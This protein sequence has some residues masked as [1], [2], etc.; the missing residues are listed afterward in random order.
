V[1]HSFYW[2]STLLLAERTGLEPATPGVTG[3]YSNQ[4][5]YRSKSL[6]LLRVKRC[7]P[8]SGKPQS[9]RVTFE[10]VLQ[11]RTEVYNENHGDATF[12]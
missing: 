4:L 9:L 6:L 11:I 10:A 8:E 2:V 7:E 12:S 5:N 1:E 3:R